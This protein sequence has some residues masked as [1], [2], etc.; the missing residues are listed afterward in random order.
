MRGLG[1][2]D[3]GRLRWSQA[4]TPIMQTLQS[5]LRIKDESQAPD[6]VFQRGAL[7][8]QAASTRLQ[9]EVRKTRCGWLKAKIVSWATNRSRS[10][11]GLREGPKF[12]IVRMMG[13]LRQG[14]LKSG[15]DLVQEGIL[16]QPDD[17]FFLTLSELEALADGKSRDWTE[18]IAKRQRTY[19]REK[20]RRQIPRLLLSDGQAFYEGLSTP[21]GTDRTILVGSPVSPGV[22]EG[23]VRVIMDPHATN[24]HPGEI[25]V[26][27]G[28]DPAWT[29]LFLAA[30]GLV[31]EVGG[32]M[33]H[34]SVV[35]REYGI[36]A[37]VGVHQATQKLETGQ[38]IQVDGNSGQIVLLEP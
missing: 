5:Y 26:C 36:P 10:L 35:A 32:M 4:P 34:G 24:L 14:L 20:L 12:Y 18:L 30:G 27:P 38:R 1:E 29:P 2:I 31:M 13:I 16:N 23:L 11:A 9:T 17:L 33:T 25:L 22:A 15:Q 7:A 28:T 3:M 19:E 6:V 21:A 8:A 37:V